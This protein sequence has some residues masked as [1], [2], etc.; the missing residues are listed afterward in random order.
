MDKF[1]RVRVARPRAQTRHLQI[2]VIAAR[3]FVLLAVICSALAVPWLASAQTGNANYFISDIDTTAFPVVRFRMRAVD[4]SN[5]VITN[6]NNTNVSVYESDGSNTPEALQAEVTPKTDGAVSIIFVIDQGRSSNYSSFG[7]GN[8]RQAITTLTSGGFF[9]DGVDTVMVMGRQN[10]NSDQTVNNLLPATQNGAA[11]STWAANFG[12]QRGNGNTKALE[13][14]SDAISQMGTLV[15][16]PGTQAAHIILVTRYI[17]DPAN[18]V[19][20]NIAPNYA[21]LAKQKFIPV[22]VFHIDQNQFNSQPLKILADNTFGQYAPLLKSNFATPVSAVYQ[23]I[24]AQRAYYEVVYTS[25]LGSAD[26][27][28]LFINTPQDQLTCDNSPTSCFSVETE[29]P[30][31]DITND[32][33]DVLRTVRQDGDEAFFLPN[34]V[35]VTADIVWPDGHPRAAVAEIFQGD[36]DDALASVE[37]DAEDTSFAIPF[38][39]SEFSE[40]GSTENVEA[41]VVVEDILGLVAEDTIEFKITNPSLEPTATPTAKP[42]IDIGGG[43]DSLGL[44]LAIGGGVVFGLIVLAAIVVFVVMRGR[45]PAPAAAPAAA[46]A[47][48][49]RGGGG[50]VPAAPAGG[51]FGGGGDVQN[52]LIAGPAY[53]ETILAKLTVLVGPKNMIG[54]PLSIVKPTTVLGRN[55]QKADIIFYSDEES[56]VS[57]VHCTIQLD[58][59]EFKI[60]DNGSRSGTRVNG[61]QLKPN[62][63]MPLGND[64]EVVMGDLG[65][66]GIKLKFNI[67]SDPNDLKAAGDR[68]FIYNVEPSYDGGSSASLDDDSKWS[69]D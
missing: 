17:E 2:A 64:A 36:S 24:N 26:Q 35:T 29:E 62:D 6:L 14:V 39:I 59:S 32:D 53:Q 51:A 20:T 15:P 7:L 46:P 57:R 30:V 69:E 19:A 10:I 23:A 47:N 1:L 40:P 4:L 34:T 31:V 22:H 38:D 18:T 44:W 12:F 67:V 28:Q 9:Q 41:R 45:Q 8:I 66:N 27:R 37:I 3:L 50:A 56:S 60:T 52:T 49:A 58:G 25:T 21:D 33:D 11:L 55:P 13:G 42:I 68:T 65:K 16:N 61:W 63:P 5:N 54:E 43:G 48:A